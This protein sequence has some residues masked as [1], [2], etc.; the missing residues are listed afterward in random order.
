MSGHAHG[1]AISSVQLGITGFGARRPVLGRRRE[2]LCI[3]VLLNLYTKHE[4]T[5]ASS[6]PE[7]NEFQVAI[8]L[9]LRQVIIKFMK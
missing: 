9:N 8:I 1:L 7:K 6:M 2:F 5:K 3:Y 4:H